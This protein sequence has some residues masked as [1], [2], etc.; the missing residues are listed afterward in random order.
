MN[1]AYPEI[2][3]R[4][5]DIGR[6]NENGELMFVSRKDFQIKHMGHRIELGEIEV[7]VN[8]VEG[9]DIAGCVY[10][11][12]KSR[13]VLFYVGE[14]LEKDLA[15][16]IKKKIPRYMV[17]N[18]FCKIDEMP[19]TPNGKIDRKTLLDQCCNGL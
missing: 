3:Y 1:P 16:L 11:K 18:R 17:P 5:G 8:A 15:A 9:V 19:H 6:L 13:I 12:K 4:T 10:E 14:I 2:I 7:Y